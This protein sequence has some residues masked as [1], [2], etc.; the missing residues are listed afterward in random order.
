MEVYDSE[1][2]QVEAIKSWWKDNGTAVIIGAVVGLG[3]L[4]GWRYYQDA[5]QSAREAASQAYTTA[6]A[7]IEQGNDESLKSVNAFIE[8]NSETEYSVLASL[9]L[10]KAYVESD[11]KEEALKQLELAKSSTSDSALTTV[12]TYRLARLQASMGNYDAA[13]TQLNTIQSDSW[14]ANVAELRGDIA[15]AQNNTEAAYSAYVE[16]QQVNGNDPLLQMKLDDLAK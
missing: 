7:N 2:Q 13:E 4:F 6:I 1:E 14:K 16:A 5:E 9:H 8:S 3:G 12:I 11:K 10:A 15:L